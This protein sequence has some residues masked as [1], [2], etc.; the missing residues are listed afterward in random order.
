M[1][2]AE[3]PSP[4]SRR[5]STPPFTATRSSS[6]MAPTTRPSPS[7]SRSP[8]GRQTGLRR[9]RSSRPASTASRFRPTTRR[10]PASASAA[11]PHTVSTAKAIPGSPL[12][13]TPYPKNRPASRSRLRAARTSRGTPSLHAPASLWSQRPTAPSATTPAW[14]EALVVTVSGWFR[15][16]PTTS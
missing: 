13:T 6:A 4:P 5:L 10:S 11:A 7:Q 3:E 9:Q 14:V 8:S 15:A 16:A 12:P 2:P 1:P